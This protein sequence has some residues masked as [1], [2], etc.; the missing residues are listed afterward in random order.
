MTFLIN[1]PSWYATDNY[2]WIVNEPKCPYK[3]NIESIDALGIPAEFFDKNNKVVTDRRK[4]KRLRRKSSRCF[5]R[6]PEHYLFYCANWR[7][8]WGY[9][10][11]DN[12]ND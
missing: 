6:L 11:K 4:I 7:A 10:Q 1:P 2:V 8:T 12:N 5:Q 3:P 9:Q